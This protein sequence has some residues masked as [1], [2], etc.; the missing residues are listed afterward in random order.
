MSQIRPKS[1]FEKP[2]RIVMGTGITEKTYKKYMRMIENYEYTFKPF[3]FKSSSYC[4]DGFSTWWNDYYSRFLIGNAEH[5]LGMVESGFNVPSLTKTATV[6][7]RGKKNNLAS[8][9]LY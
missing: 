6:S 2:D 8:I 5:M 3:E 7:S 1:F 4:T 9:L